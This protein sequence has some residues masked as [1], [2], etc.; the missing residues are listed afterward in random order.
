MAHALI[1]AALPSPSSNA[2][3]IGPLSIRAYGLAIGIGVVLAVHIAQRRWEARGGD[4]ADIASVAVWAVPAGLVG[5][6]L[7]HVVTDWHR[8]EGRWLHA[9]AVWEGGLG[10][11]GGLV[12]GV[13]TGVV[14]ARRRG[15]PVAH[16]LDVVAPAIPVAQAVGRLGNWFNQELFGRPSDLPW[17]LRIDPAHRPDGFADVATYHPTFLY[18]GLWNLALAGLLVYVGHRWRP[19]VGQ[20]F[21]GYVAGYAAGRLWVEALRIDPATE[22]AGVRVNIWVSSA[23]LLAAVVVLVLR[24]R[25]GP[26]GHR[27]TPPLD[28][29]EQRGGTTTAPG[30]LSC[31]EV[32]E[33]LQSFLDQE[34]DDGTA[35]QVEAHLEMCRRCGLE[36]DLYREIKDSLTRSAQPVPELT[37]WRLRRFGDEL[38]TGS[39]GDPHGTGI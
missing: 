17:A 12:V 27:P 6:R 16:L 33:V 18:E 2:I 20:L 8:F 32:A 24:A 4:S 38:R 7:Y 19:R 28:A 37:L 14:V 1:L 26:P 5:A 25:T 11:P 39:S 29:V 15:L 30:A 9:F 22:I 31:H 3:D 23:V 13:A 35:G 36:G 10:I 21:V 34:V